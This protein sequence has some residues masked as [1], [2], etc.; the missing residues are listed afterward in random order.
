VSVSRAQ[1]YLDG[2]GKTRHKV[3]V[4]KTDSVFT[5]DTS[6]LARSEAF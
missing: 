1:S 2:Q 6:Q 5:T 4:V 3:T